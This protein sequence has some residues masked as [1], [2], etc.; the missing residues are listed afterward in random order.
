MYNFVYLA[1]RRSQE[2]SC[3]PNFGGVPS[4]PLGCASG[5]NFF[6]TQWKEAPMP[7][8]SSPSDNDFEQYRTS[9]IRSAVSTELRLV[10]DTD[11]Q[12]DGETGPWLVPTL[13]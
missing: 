8:P 12:T 3:E 2:F 4:A 13:A 1:Q 7:K 11:R 5:L 6:L 9:S 10:T